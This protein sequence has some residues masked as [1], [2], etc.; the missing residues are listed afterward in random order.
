VNFVAMAKDVGG[1]FGVPEASL[2]AK[3]HTSFQHFAH[4]DCHDEVS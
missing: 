2:V 3:V 1:H 4:G